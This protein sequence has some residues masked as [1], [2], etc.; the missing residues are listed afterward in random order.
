M[1]QCLAYVYGEEGVS[2]TACAFH[3]V[4]HVLFLSGYSYQSAV[5]A[6]NVGEATLKYTVYQAADFFTL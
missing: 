6:S 3:P 2:M 4:E 1:K 5:L